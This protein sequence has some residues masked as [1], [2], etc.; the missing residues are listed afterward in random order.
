MSA[1]GF[2]LLNDDAFRERVS[3]V[4]TE[5]KRL[6]RDPG[7]IKISNFIPVAMAVETEEAARQTIAA[8]AQMFQSEPGDTSVFSDGIGADV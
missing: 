2:R 3:Y 6:G 7:A 8:V 4:R 5:A 1:E